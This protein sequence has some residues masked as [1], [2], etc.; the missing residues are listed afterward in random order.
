MPDTVLIVEDEP[1]MGRILQDL[2]A[3]RKSVV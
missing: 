1:K 2:F 3:D